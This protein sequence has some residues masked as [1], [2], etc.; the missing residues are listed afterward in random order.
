LG[1]GANGQNAFNLGWSFWLMTPSFACSILAGLIGSMILGCTC[2]TNVV[3]REIQT[4]KGNVQQIRHT[5]YI[6]SSGV[7]NQ[8][9]GGQ[10]IYFSNDA[11]DPQVLRL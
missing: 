10:P 6:T 9:Y 11:A 5:T 4:T 2:V 3:A 1:T 8:G 7:D